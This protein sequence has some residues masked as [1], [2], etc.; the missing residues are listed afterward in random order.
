MTDMAASAIGTAG[1]E[2]ETR[3]FIA[4]DAYPGWSRPPVNV[5]LILIS[6]LLP[7]AGGVFLAQFLSWPGISPFQ[8]GLF[9]WSLVA[10]SVISL[11]TQVGTLV[12]RHRI[13][14]KAWREHGEDL[15]AGAAT[16]DPAIYAG[17]VVGAASRYV[18]ERCVI[19]FLAS[20]DDPAACRAFLDALRTAGEATMGPRLAGMTRYYAKFL[21]PKSPAE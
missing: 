15:L 8:V 13:Q 1:A 19:A 18:A 3:G 11:A 14:E 20:H 5:E 21:D 17:E 10:L 12:L 9:T 4:A 6:S 16:A 2:A 7:L